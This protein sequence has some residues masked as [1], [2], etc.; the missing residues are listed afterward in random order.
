[1]AEGHEDVFAYI[2]RATER[3]WSW[4]VCD[5]HGEVVATGEEGSRHDAQCAIDQ[6]YAGGGHPSIHSPRRGEYQ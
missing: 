1:M 3:G 2:L 4:L 5:Q 6:A